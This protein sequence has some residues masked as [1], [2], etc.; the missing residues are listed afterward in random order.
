MRDFSG[1]TAVVTGAA[2]GIGRGLAERFAS[3]GMNVV[4]ADV[5]ERALAEVVTALQG[6]GHRALGVVT[7][8]RERRA[9]AAL[10][11][12]A[13]R[14]FGK[15]HVLCNNAG[16]LGASE[17]ARAVWELPAADWDWVLG[18]NFS[19][20]L[21]GI[22]ELVPRMLAHGEPG[23]VV[24]TASIAAFFPGGGP[25]GVSKHG[26]LSL[27]ESLWSDLRAR[28]SRLGASVLCPGWV[29][30]RLASAERNRPAELAAG[31]GG[32]VSGGTAGRARETLRG[33]KPPA[34][35]ADA[36]LA[37]IRDERFYI[38]T[39]PGW[40]FVLRARLEA[41]LARS[42][43]FVLDFAEIARRRAGGEVF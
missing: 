20:V 36:V 32:D 40:D 19:G 38:L 15:V 13:E 30:T 25:Y 26:V 27:S 35:V 21:H 42:T 43:P 41:A 22:Q 18:V 16:V 33:A 8:V 6:R 12:A 1:R 24:N 2:S 29:D 14:A 10:A 34:E 4:L 5:E 7:D 17:G 11:D 37:A 3:E 39:H 28:G 9:V 31:F 23:H